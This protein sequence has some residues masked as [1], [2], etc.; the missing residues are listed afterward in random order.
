LLDAGQA[1]FPEA[2]ANMPQ[3]FTGRMLNWAVTT[4]AG[5]GFLLMGYGKLRIYDLATLWLTLNDQTKV[6]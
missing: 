2:V 4:T 6:S 3:L 1:H 5:T